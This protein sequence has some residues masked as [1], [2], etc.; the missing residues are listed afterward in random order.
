MRMKMRITAAVLGVVLAF[1]SAVQAAE[2]F[3]N[4]EGNDGNNGRTR[5][6]AFLTIRKGVNALKPGDT[7]TI[8]PGEYFENVKRDNFGS[9]DADTII[10]AEIPRTAMMRGDV[11]APEFEK[12]E[13]YRFVY[14]G[15]FDQ[16]PLAVLEHDTLSVLAKRPNLR[17]VEY[18]PGTFYY[19]ENAKRLYMSTTDLRVPGNRRYTIAVSGK[20]GIE[21]TKPQRIVI[22]GLGA[23]GFYP[24]WGIILDEPKSC[25]VRDCVWYLCSGGFQANRGSHKVVENCESYGHTFGGIVF[26]YADNDVIR[27]CRTYMTKGK[28]EHFGIMHYHGMPGPFL[29]T[30]NISWGQAF[31]LSVKPGVQERLERNVGLGFV[32]NTPRNMFHNLIAGSNEFDRGSSVAADNILFVREE[33]LD[34]DFEFADPLNLDFRLQPDSRFRGT[35]PD[36]GDRGPYPYEENIYYVSPAGDDGADGMSMRKPWR[37]PAQAFGKL[38]PG[39]TLYLAEGEYAAAPLTKAGDGKSPIRILGRGRGTV[40]ITGKQTVAASAGVVF[41]RLNFADGVSLS[42]CR[43]LTFKNCTFFGEA[44]GL[45]PDGVKNLKV[46][47]CV[48]A[49]LPLNVK[50]S[51]GLFLSGNL[52]GNAG[53]PALT[54]DAEAA[55][56]YSDYNNYANAAQS[57]EVNGKTWSFADLQQRHDR[58]SQILSPDLVA[59]GD[60]PR[61]GNEDT[62]KCRGPHSKTVGVH[63]AYDPA[64]KPLRLV[65]PFLHSVSD[66]TANIEWWASRPATFKLAWGETPE[67]TNKIENVQAPDCFTTYSLTGLKPGTRYYF[68]IESADTAGR[69]DAM[70]ATAL[71]PE[72]APLSL[73]TMAVALKPVVYYVAPD[74]DDANTGLS[75]AEAWRTVSH[76]ADVVNAGDTVLIAGGDYHEDIRIR[77]T[78][79]E[80]RPITFKCIPGEKVVFHGDNLV[81]GFKAV[82]KKHLY[83]DG[84]YFVKFGGVPEAVFVLWQAEDVRI[85]RC[86]NVK[87][88]GYGGFVSAKYSADL[89]VSNCVMAQGSPISLHI[90]PDCRIENNLF[91]RAYIVAFYFVNKPE[92]K[93][94]VRKNVF[95]GNLPYKSHAPLIIAGRF[96]SLVCEDNCFFTRVPIEEKNLL[97]FY[98]TAAY[99][100]YDRYG[101]TTDFEK[102]PVIVDHPDGTENNP[103]MTLAQYEKLAGDTG[104]FVGDPKFAGNA[105]VKPGGKLWTGDPATMF[106]KLLGKD[107]L[108]FPDT[109]VTDPK[110]VEKGIGPQ[111]EAFEDFWFNKD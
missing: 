67:T 59:E 20:H 61:L 42:D 111:P 35:A 44:D 73:T 66:T 109:F 26:Y 65:G 21:L 7:L 47:H 99:G 87:G 108:D 39:D 86:F 91:L 17:D 98:G 57:W 29:I 103:K 80:G 106:D 3:V 9:P 88:T 22:E 32:R 12:V 38:R 13:G 70:S 93:A 14:A 43:D 64:P 102:T 95:A 33:N 76:A 55:I 46:T 84:L 54:V 30:N 40:I 110:A 101:V 96:E 45:N 89:S 94:Y 19:D 100:R 97:Q 52:Y 79:D 31:N 104:S 105:N 78:G 72:A 23:S 56:L 10:R 25:T 85:T 36:G 49:G 69:E 92:Q 28:G 16:A 51:S 37:T 68:K 71:K 60:V 5:Q 48:F 24:G 6:T 4:K 1:G 50:N 53:Q 62:F 18:E 34:K 27:D 11:D 8:G 15:A 58:Y 90:C 75:R 74:G 63:H 77:A 41:E 82:A 83:F 2:Y 81:Q 107:G